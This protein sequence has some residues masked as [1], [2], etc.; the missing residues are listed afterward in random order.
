MN[1]KKALDKFTCNTYPIEFIPLGPIIDPVLGKGLPRRRLI[2]LF[3]PY[4]GGKT[5]I[6]CLAVAATQRSGL[7]AVYIDVEHAFDPDYAIF[8]GVD[9]EGLSLCQPESA[10][11]ALDATLT[12][13]KHGAGIVVLDSVGGLVTRE[14]LEGSEAHAPVA[15]LLA[16]KLRLLIQAAKIG[17]TCLLFINQTRKQINSMIPGAEHTCGGEALKFF[18]SIRVEVRRVSSLKW[19]EKV[20][21]FKSK[22]RTIK[23]KLAPPF[24]EGFF[25]LTFDPEAPDIGGVENLVAVGEVKALAGGYFEYE[26]KKYH[27]KER[28]SEALDKKEMKDGKV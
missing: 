7:E 26:G 11:E 14:E 12:A 19:V 3:G 20:V 8:L 1:L 16:N 21:G 25:S 10:E 13:C 18:A 2:E 5:S 23:N 27:G 6:A 28:V 15:R 22:V 4:G 24:K 17:N 9:V